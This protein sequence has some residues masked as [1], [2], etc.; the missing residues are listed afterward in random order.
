MPVEKYQPPDKEIL[1]R[2]LPYST[3]CQLSRNLVRLNGHPSL[4]EPVR[5]QINSPRRL[6]ARTETT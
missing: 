6:R 1:L 4:K 2:H 3:S 5:M